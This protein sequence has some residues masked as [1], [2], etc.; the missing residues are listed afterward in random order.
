MAIP[1]RFYVV[2]DE[3]H[4]GMR[5]GRVAETAQT[6]MQ[7]FLMGSESDGLCQM[8]L[9]IGISAT[10]K[11]FEDLLLGTPHSIHKIRIAAD[12]VRESGL[13]KDRI[14][15]DYPDNESQAEMS[16]LEQAAIRWRAIGKRWSSYCKKEGESVV[17]PALVIQIEDGTPKKLT[18]TDLKTCLSSLEN[19]IGR[20]LR[21][22]EIA[23]TFGDSGDLEIDGRKIHYIEPSRIE[24]DHSIGIV[25]FK[26]SL[27]TGWDC[28]RAEVMMSFRAAQQHTYIAQLLG[29][30][31]RTPLARRVPT[32]SALNDVHLFLPHYDQTT[33]ESV[34]Q[35]LENDE[36]VPPSEAGTS[37]EMVTLYKRDDFDDVF[38]AMA[39][40]ITYRVNA[41]RKQKSLRRLMS[42]GRQLTQDRID[43]KAQERIA[44]QIVKEITAGVKRLKDSGTFDDK[45]KQVTGVDLKTM[46]ADQ[47]TG[48]STITGGYTIEAASADI[49]RHF[50]QAGRLLGNGLHMDYWRSNGNRDANEVKV[51]AVVLSQDHDEM[52][53][54]ESFAQSEFDKLYAKH[55]RK[56]AKLKKH[57]Q[58]IYERL[59]LATAKPQSVPWTVQDSIDF[60]RPA[61]AP[62]YDKHLYIEEDGKF[63]AS[64]GT[65]E[66]ELLKDELTNPS[67]IGWLRNVE[68]KSWSL[69]IPYPVV[70][71]FKPM[72]PDFVI[73]RKE[74]DGL[75]F[76]ILEPHDPSRTDNAPKALGL[77]RFAEDHW[78]KFS[79]IQLIRKFAG[80]DGV[81]RYHRLDVGK[82]P[83]RRKVL[84]IKSNDEL[85]QIFDDDSFV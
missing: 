62:E 7:K 12:D 22:G 39:D 82:D 34:I 8:P 71:G 78:N 58:M 60:K 59:R 47:R 57:R 11:R 67:V 49:D 84:R 46:A 55:K 33:V 45:A 5:S 73:V 52:K 38:E 32:D 64:L 3:A 79:R 61:T 74:K 20:R 43:K 30:M 37:R 70:A 44:T 15:I 24:E 4:R 54:L 16:L 25:I 85:D 1:D 6:I 2:I 29:R 14:L 81:D 36:D 35:D 31:V 56:I 80:A 48:K 68:R 66:R 83:I 9:V 51:E 76:D 69:E 13:L 19:A 10:P 72:F 42:I 23:H 50:E 18:K 75:E 41:V 65:W 28:P 63:K 40:L 27:S 21:D 77:A 26:M 53:E 17:L